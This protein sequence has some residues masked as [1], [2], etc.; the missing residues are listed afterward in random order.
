MKGVTRVAIV[1]VGV[2]CVLVALAYALVWMFRGPAASN[3]VIGNANVIGGLAGLLALVLAVAPLLHA[4]AQR[5]AS[6]APATEKAT[7]VQVAADHLAAETLRYW[8]DQAKDRK[9]TTPSPVTVR[10]RWAG[11]EVAVPA[12]ELQFRTEVLTAGV[13][14]QLR[15]QLFDRLDAD[16]TR[17]VLLGEAGAG[18]TA[19][20]ML[21]LIDVLKH[22]SEGSRDP[23][24]I[25]LTLGGWD[26]T[27]T[28]LRDW[29]A[30]TL[31]RDY[32]GLAAPE[33]GGPDT[34]VQLIRT[35]RVALFLDGLDEMPSEGQGAA[36]E[37]ID[38]NAT[39]LR[40]VLTS[41][42][43]QYRTALT[44]G[45]LYGAA[46][47]DLLPVD[48]DQAQQFLLAEQLGDRRHAW[49]QVIDHIRAH[50]DSPA[51]RT[52][53]TPLSLSLARDTYTTAN[54]TH[55]LNTDQHPTPD[56]LLQHLLTQSLTIAYPNPARRAHAI[57]WLSWI[58]W[59]MDPERDLRWWDIPT[60]L[61]ERPRRMA[62]TLVVG[63]KYGLLVGLP[64]A[65]VVGLVPALVLGV[66]ITLVVGL[67]VSLWGAYATGFLGGMAFASKINVLSNTPYRITVRWPTGGEWR[68]E[69]LAAL[70]A[71]SP[72][73]VYRTDRRR[74]MTFALTFA[75]TSGLAF[76]LTSGLTGL[77]VGLAVGLAFGLIIGLGPA[78]Q[79]AVVEAIW[80]LLLLKR[81]RFMP[82]LQTA[83]QKQVLRQA[84]AEYQF[85]H[86]A[87]Q[88][89]LAGAI[90]LP[91]LGDIHRAMGN[92][93]A[94]HDAWQQA[95]TILDDLHHPDAEQVRAKLAGL[96][97]A[98]VEPDDGDAYDD[99]ERAGGT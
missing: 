96:D 46:V 12:R 4:A 32:P 55:L 87:L 23:V 89:L 75:L 98:T 81:V 69:R 66:V 45:R 7:Q 64:S 24:P 6:A 90:T 48:V 9:I 56:A 95:L 94:A 25:W 36:L 49:Q 31:I 84:G 30:A 58:A 78:V 53:T 99:S 60:W 71:A 76:G 52:L 82:L 44:Q 17:M 18:K 68:D 83:L 14:T 8:Q 27:T 54:P 22:R 77:A 11:D 10:W 59:N 57:F 37:A 42:P 51:A 29:A 15:E 3:A 92:R 80:G 62:F 61:P 74:T 20:M 21:L 73:E 35:G 72:L 2:T 88:D 43:E 91:H 41:R 16:Q 63:L 39:G 50:P 93:H 67:V 26:P 85:R 34:A 5:R 33:H 70:R 97:T 79:L 47:I 1:V 13:V 65:L 40:V 19:A 86:A 28:S 38:R